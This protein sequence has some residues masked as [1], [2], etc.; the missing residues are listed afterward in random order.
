MTHEPRILA[1]DIETRPAKAYVWNLFDETI[2]IDQL[3]EP[4]GVICVGAQWVGTNE[5]LFD[6]DWTC[7]HK[8]MLKRVHY[9]ISR[10]DAVL[11][12]NGDRFDLPKLNG[13]F[14]LN[15][16]GPTPPVTSIDLYKV[17]KGFRYDSGKLAF[18]GP[19]LG[20]GA[21]AENA[22]FTLWARVMAGD[23]GARV[24]MERYCLQDVRLLVQAYG[25]MKP[26]IKNHPKLLDTAKHECGACGSNRVQARGFRRTRAF[27]IQRLQCQ[28]CGSWFDGTR[29][30]V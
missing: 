11:T 27:K 29:V 5:V 8:T 13:E 24:D 25:R 28:D 17:V 10:A 20:I 22:G 21:K 1:L 4:G 2:G 23:A 7:G 26:F 19:H 3:I 15:G 14:I 30:K 6:A 18:V 16:L 9:E 12:Y